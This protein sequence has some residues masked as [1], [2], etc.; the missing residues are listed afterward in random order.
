MANIG[1]I[2]R[3]GEHRGAQTGA[4]LRFP[5]FCDHLQA[6]ERL[7]RATTALRAQEGHGVSRKAHAGHVPRVLQSISIYYSL[8]G[9]QNSLRP[10]P[11]MCI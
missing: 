10:A 9:K 8:K 4:E 2:L 11:V 1:A 5:W 7:V 3:L 6:P